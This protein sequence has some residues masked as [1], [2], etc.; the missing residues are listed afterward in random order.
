VPNIASLELHIVVLDEGEP[1]RR[2]NGDPMASNEADDALL[3]AVDAAE[4]SLKNDGIQIAR[5][6]Y[7]VTARRV[8]PAEI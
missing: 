6:G 2:W 3:R 7:G 5:M 1:R 4:T 8:L